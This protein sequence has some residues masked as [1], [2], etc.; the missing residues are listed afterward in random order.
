MINI[1][2]FT[3]GN[4]SPLETFILDLMSDLYQDKDF[5]V[6]YISGSN[7]KCKITNAYECCFSGFDTSYSQFAF[8]LQKISA[9]KGGDKA[10]F[11]RM[12][13]NLWKSNKQLLKQKLP[14]FD[15]AYIEYANTAILVKDFL[16]D[17]N[18]PF[19]VHVHGHDITASTNNEA[20]TKEL[21]DLFKKATLFIAA[22]NYMK[23]RL[24]LLGCQ[25]N[26]IKMIRLGVKTDNIKIVPW[27]EK[28]KNNPSLI[29]LGR[30]TEK[31][32][33]IALLHAFSIVKS[34]IPNISLTIIGGGPLESIVRQE[35][36]KLGLSNSVNLKGVLEREQSFPI[37]SSHWIYV[38][39]SVTSIKGDTEGFGLGMAEAALH[40]LP[41]VSTIHNGITENV[42]DSK[43]GFLVPE[44]D[45]EQMADKIIMLI[46]N[47]ILAQQMGKDGRKHILNLCKPSKRNELIKQSIKEVVNTNAII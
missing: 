24:V 22:S 41:I 19:I 18:I 27:S 33:P 30:L 39:H 42:I 10:D 37:L 6:T 44:Y 45:Y 3:I 16:F 40:E 17:N 12:K 9:I 11:I 29:F 13:F 7:K 28:L 25:P 21:K 36:K 34:K 4:V 20:Y 46:N 14:H 43:T 31:K 38:Q 26:K 15:A 1:G 5:K 2:F 47:P 23:R 8:Y 35:I 32:H